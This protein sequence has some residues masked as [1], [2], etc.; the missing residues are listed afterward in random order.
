MLG[1]SDEGKSLFN[2]CF[3]GFIGTEIVWLLL[4]LNDDSVSDGDLQVFMCGAI[5]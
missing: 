3:R 4:S 2:R 5:F 1:L